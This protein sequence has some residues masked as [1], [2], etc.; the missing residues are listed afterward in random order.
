MG[1]EQHTI[2]TERQIPEGYLTVTALRC[3]I[4]HVI[5]MYTCNFRSGR[6]PKRGDLDWLAVNHTFSEWLRHPQGPVLTANTTAK[7]ASYVSF[8]GKS[9]DDFNGAVANL[10]SIDHVLDTNSLT[11][12]WNN[13]VV[14]RYGFPLFNVYAN[15]SSKSIDIT[16]D[17]VQY[18]RKHREV[19]FD[20]C[21]VFGI[22][23][24]LA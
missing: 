11:Q 13:S 24:W 14:P 22:K 16:E 19:D 4:R 7:W 20:I 1:T 21:K 5:S 12:Q 9:G 15:R 23:T 8:F 2:F 10:K 18:I 17:D 6:K 3:P